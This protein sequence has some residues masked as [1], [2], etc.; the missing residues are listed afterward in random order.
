MRVRFY[1]PIERILAR[2]KLN[3]FAKVRLGVKSNK[4]RYR[5]PQTSK[6]TSLRGTCRGN[7]VNLDHL[8]IL[9]YYNAVIRGI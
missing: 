8:D 1:A 3:K 9:R 2:L 6:K 7:L 5:T 4:K